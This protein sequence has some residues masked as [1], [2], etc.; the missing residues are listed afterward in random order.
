[1]YPVGGK[2]G[3]LAFK[4][5]RV[6]RFE[7]VV[8]SDDKHTNGGFMMTKLSR[9]GGAFILLLT[10]S[11]QATA[12]DDDGLIS[13]ITD[14]LDVSS[15]EARGGAGAIFAYAED[16]LD[17]YDFDRIAEG[18][19]DMDSLLDAAPEVD[20]DSG[21]GRAS[22]VLGDVFG[23]A[24]GGRAYLVESFDEL[25]MD[26]DMINEFLSIVYDYVEDESG[27]RAMEM[28]EDLFVDF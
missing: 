5:L 16:N 15:P 24:M 22:D 12:G 6:N 11:F 2:S 27:E 25:D 9:I 1:M 3:N 7:E 4:R 23:G 8:L 19:P 17:D 20:D 14:E 13:L 18:I 10:L 26:R 21:M 28:L